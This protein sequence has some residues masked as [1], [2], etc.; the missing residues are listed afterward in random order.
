MFEMT[1]V[2]HSPVLRS[3]RPRVEIFMNTRMWVTISGSGTLC[4]SIHGRDRQEGNMKAPVLSGGS[5]TRASRAGSI[6][7]MPGHE[8]TLDNPSIS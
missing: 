4:L 8:A 6:E 1:D 2:T 5:L 3:R 7:V